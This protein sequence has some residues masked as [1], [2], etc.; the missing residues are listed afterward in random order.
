MCSTSL[1]AWHR[2]SQIIHGYVEPVDPFPVPKMYLHIANS[3]SAFI[4]IAFDIWRLID[5]DLLD[6]RRDI[7]PANVT[8]MFTEC[9]AN[10]SKIA[11]HFTD[12]LRLFDSYKSIGLRTTMEV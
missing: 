5:G 1:Y 2:L 4:N 3:V 11:I 9:S 7:R 6:V 10:M 12:Q 8:A